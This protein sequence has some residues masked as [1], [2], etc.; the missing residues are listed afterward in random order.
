MRI[1]TA[2]V[3]NQA[4]QSMLDQQTQASR[5]Q[6]QIGSGRR[7]LTPAEDPV[8]AARVLALSQTTA[9]TEQFQR[10]I[11]AAEARLRLEDG[12]LGGVTDLVQR[13]R[14]LAVQGNNDSNGADDRRFIASEVRQLLDELLR[15]ANTT[16]ETGEYLFSGFRT[17]TQPFVAAGGA[18]SYNG[19]Q[20]QRFIAVGPGR[21]IAAGDSG[22]DVFLAIPDGNG[23]FAVSAGAANAGTGVADQGTVLTAFTPDSYRLTFIQALPT[24]PITYEVRRDPAGANTLVASGTYVDGEAIAFGGSLGASEAQVIVKGTPTNGDTFDIAPSAAQDL[25]TT[26]EN[27][28]L[29][30]E[31]GGGDAAARAQFHGAMNRVLSELDL[32]LEN[33]LDVRARVGGRLNSLEGQRNINA[34][35]KLQ[36]EQTLSEVQDL[37]YAEAIGRFNLELVA[38]QAAQQSFARIQGLSLFNFL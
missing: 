37:D 17:R 21:Q 9:I 2:Q 12:A 31:S 4:I 5:T 34:D 18:F 13:A 28:A 3:F 30:L 26:F 24:D 6:L 32:G 20:G 8:G 16:D 25:F 33:I 19:D 22:A 38:L 27:L 29:N 35:F 23:T 1:S 36:L 14:E 10:N 11:D 7:I 15:L